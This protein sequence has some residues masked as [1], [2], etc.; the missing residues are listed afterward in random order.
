MMRLFVG[1]ELPEAV[2]RALGL[3]RGGIRGAKWQRDDQFH[4]TLR[5]IGE[6]PPGRVEEIVRALAGIAF[7]S[8]ELRLAGIGLFGRPRQPRVLWAGVESPAPLRHLARKVNQALERAGVEEAH[9]R[10]APHVTIARFGRHAGPVEEWI[11]HHRDFALPP[12]PVS[13]FSLF[14]SHLLGDGARYEI[15]ARFPAS[16]AETVEDPFQR[17][18]VA[19]AEEPDVDQQGP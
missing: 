3:L 9:R 11:A 14:E 15:E 6:V 16:D 12:F 7:P 17:G 5:F 4:L 8:F 1:I 10:F 19:A 18:E 13:H 2:R